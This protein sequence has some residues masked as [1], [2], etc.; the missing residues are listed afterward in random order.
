[1]TKVQAGETVVYDIELTDTFGGEANYCWVRR[2]PLRVFIPAGL[3]RKQEDSRIK[4][5]AKKAMGLTG[6]RGDWSDYGDQFDFRPRGPTVVL[7]VTWRDLSLNPLEDD[8]TE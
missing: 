7:F 4:R 8:E 3:T 6:M 5:A 2:K 1:M